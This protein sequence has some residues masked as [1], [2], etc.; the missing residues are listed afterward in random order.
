MTAQRAHNNAANGLG[1]QER[2]S[3]GKTGILH[4]LRGAVALKQQV[5]HRQVIEEAAQVH[6][7]GVTKTLF[8]GS[9]DPLA[10][11]AVQV[12]GMAIPTSTASTMNVALPVAMETMSR[13]NSGENSKANGPNASLTTEQVSST[14][15][16]GSGV[17]FETSSRTSGNS[18]TGSPLLPFEMLSLPPGGTTTPA[19]GHPTSQKSKNMAETKPNQDWVAP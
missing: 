19:P 5:L 8:E 14:C 15:S 16:L 13:P 3:P 11:V 12:K 9:L 10:L 17:G 1:R 18:A 2:E 4:R 6:R 7:V